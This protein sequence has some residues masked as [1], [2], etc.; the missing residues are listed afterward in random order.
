MIKPRVRFCWECGNKLVGNIHVE[1]VVEEHSRILH[2]MCWK[3]IKDGNRS[4][5]ISDNEELE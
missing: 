4:L 5:T 1:K 2:K 3:L